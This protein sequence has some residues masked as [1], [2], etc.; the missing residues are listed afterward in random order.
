MV[1]TM[2]NVEAKRDALATLLGEI[3]N[4]AAG[5]ALVPGEGNLDAGLAIVGEA[6]GRHEETEGRPFIGRAGQ[7]LDEMLVEAGLDRKEVWI[8]NL[9]KW[10]PAK[11]NPSHSTRPPSINELKLFT[12]WLWAELRIIQPT[13]ALCLGRASA[14]AVIDRE[15]QI[16]R[17]H[18]YVYKLDELSAMVTYHPAY[19]LRF[20][21][22]KDER[23]WRMAV[24]DLRK[25]AGLYRSAQGIS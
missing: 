8:T 24:E 17:D 16:D 13:A 2:M 4:Y 22:H 7:L 23:T 20:G 25:I 6:P 18:G 1:K 19:V 9:V 3:Q 21:N 10:R 11:R 5:R 15:I 14:Q 12:P